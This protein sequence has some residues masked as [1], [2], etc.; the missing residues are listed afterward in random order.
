[1]VQIIDTDDDMEIHIENSGKK[2]FFLGSGPDRGRS[3]VEWGD[4][5]SVRLFVPLSPPLSREWVLSWKK[6]HVPLALDHM[7][8]PLGGKKQPVPSNLFQFICMDHHCIIYSK[9]HCDLL[10]AKT[11]YLIAVF[12][13]L[14]ERTIFD[15]LL[16]MAHISTCIGANLKNYMRSGKD[17]SRTTI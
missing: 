17:F 13:G 14:L 2:V 8:S 1:M 9:T 4:F 7:L 16:C 12:G 6:L 15:L 11:T 3:P 10:S 5:P